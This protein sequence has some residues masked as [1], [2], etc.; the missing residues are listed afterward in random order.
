[1]LAVELG[2][3]RGRPP[4]PVGRVGGADFAHVALQRRDPAGDAGLG[5]PRGPDL[6]VEQRGGHWAGVE[7]G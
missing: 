2:H 1:V 7:P 5:E 6:A 3:G 4:V